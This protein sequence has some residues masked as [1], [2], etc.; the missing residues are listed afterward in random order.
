[1]V[2]LPRA[3][4]KKDV[5]DMVRRLAIF[6][7]LAIVTVVVYVSLDD[8]PIQ[9]KVRADEKQLA[10]AIRKKSAQA[11]QD[12]DSPKKVLTPEEIESGKW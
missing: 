6:S 10:E 7:A 2:L 5:L 12:V 1:M 11:G 4:V 9:Q 3:G 8:H